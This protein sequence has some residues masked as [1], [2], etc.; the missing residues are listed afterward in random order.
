M[1]TMNFITPDGDLVAGYSLPIYFASEGEAGAHNVWI[2]VDERADE[3]GNILADP[4]HPDHDEWENWD[5]DFFF[6]FTPAEF[7]EFSTTGGNE[8]W[9]ILQGKD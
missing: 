7:A 2:V 8:D 4:N 1:E 6:Y 5:T 3:I 9:R